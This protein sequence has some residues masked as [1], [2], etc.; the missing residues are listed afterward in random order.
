[1]Q[2]VSGSSNYFLAKQI[3]EA[4]NIDLL[5]MKISHFAD[6]E[7]EIKINAPVARNILIVQSLQRPAGEYLL[8]LL[9]LVDI[10][11]R[12]GARNITAIIPYLGYSRQDRVTINNDAISAK[13]ILNI[14]EKSN[15]DKI[16]TLDLHSNYLT[17][18]TNIPLINIASTN[19]FLPFIQNIA[20]SALIAPD[21]GGVS[22]VE[23]YLHYLPNIHIEKFTKIRSISNLHN[24]TSKNNGKLSA[25]NYFIIDDIIDSGNSLLA[26]AK[27]L[28]EQNAISITA[29]V[30]HG[31][32]SSDA[33]NKLEKSSIDHIYLTNSLKI[34]N[35]PSKFTI[36]SAANTII[37]AFM[38]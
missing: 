9:L 15:I 6:G 16:F 29:L 34:G 3:S 17:K 28:K 36:L 10:L 30:T 32:L 20:N 35:L 7:L 12:K 31:V 24:I 37:K 4:A 8:E 33:I 27:L 1:M 5:D 2:L 14:L 19:I 26:I 25:R 38:S 11:K 22:R 18:I 23:H 13:S 21:L